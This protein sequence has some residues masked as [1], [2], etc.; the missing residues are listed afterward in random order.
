MTDAPL[1]CRDAPVA[2]DPVEVLLRRAGASLLAFAAWRERRRLT[3][4]LDG[5]N[6][7]MLADVGIAR[8]R[9][10]WLLAPGSIA[11]GQ[12]TIASDGALARHE[13]EPC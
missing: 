13:R 9:F 12:F 6:E 10:G 5:F 7:R 3:A 4:A 8:S 2:S 11:D 1:E